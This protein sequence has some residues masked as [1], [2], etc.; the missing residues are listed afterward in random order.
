MA[1]NASLAGLTPTQLRAMADTIESRDRQECTGVS[2]SWCP[3][4]GDCACPWNE[5]SGRDLSDF[6]CPLHGEHSAHA[7][8][9]DES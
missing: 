7:P 4:H 2:A 9:A 1:S 5:V 6:H 8:A 3:I